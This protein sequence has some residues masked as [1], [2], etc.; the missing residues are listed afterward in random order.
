M[1]IITIVI[2]ILAC[3]LL[4]FIYD[5]L[6]SNAK[7]MKKI[8]KSIN[9]NLVELEMSMEKKLGVINDNI[10]KMQ[11]IQKQIS[12]TNRMNEQVV[13]NKFD[14]C[15]NSPNCFI[16]K[17][18]NHEA[19][20][21]YMSPITKTSNKSENDSVYDNQDVIKTEFINML[22]HVQQMPFNF[23]VMSNQENP[24]KEED[25]VPRVE[26][27]VEEEIVEEIVE[28]NPKFENIDD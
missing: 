10:N 8:E 12:D 6:S 23:I 3:V 28:E 20:M 15:Q 24:E 19:K 9:D 2:I 11:K 27:I 25:M 22:N 5:S 17:D 7:Y 13:L 1:D 4:Y 18:D 21:F 16:E 14:V 26:E